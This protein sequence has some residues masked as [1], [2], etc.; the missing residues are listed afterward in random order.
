VGEVVSEILR[1][2]SEG[3]LTPAVHDGTATVLEVPELFTDDVLV[4]ASAGD[5]DTTSEVPVEFAEGTAKVG[6][7]EEVSEVFGRLVKVPIGVLSTVS[8]RAVETGLEEVLRP[9][10][11]LLAVSVKDWRPVMEASSPH[12]ILS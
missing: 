6:F 11:E 8:N 7:V 1:E 12:S 4:F 3:K 2:L 9:P 5:E 10:D